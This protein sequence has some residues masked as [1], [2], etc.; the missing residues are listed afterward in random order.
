MD[1][2][3]NFERK[4]SVNLEEFHESYE[5]LFDGDDSRSEPCYLPDTYSM[6]RESIKCLASNSGESSV[7]DADRSSSAPSQDFDAENA[8]KDQAEVADEEEEAERIEGDESEILDTNNGRNPSSISSNGGYEPGSSSYNSGSCSSLSSHNIDDEDDTSTR[9]RKR[10]KHFLIISN[11]GKPIYSRYGDESKLAG[12]SA[13]LHAIISYVENSGDKIRHVRAGKHQIVFMT[14]GPIHLVCISCTEE[15]FKVLSLQLELLYAQTLLILTKSIEKYFKKNAKFDMRSLL[16]GTDEVFSSLIHLFSWNPAVFLQAYTCVPLSRHARQAISMTLQDVISSQV[17]FAILMCKNKVISIAGAQKATLHPQDLLLLSNFIVSSK[18]FRTSEAFSPICIPKYN[19]AAFLHS[20]VHYLQGETFLALLSPD[21]H[22]FYHLKECRI[23]IE[24]V[25]QKSE[26]LN[27]VRRSLESG[28]YV[29][30][31]LQSQGH[32][33]EHQLPISMRRSEGVNT[34]IGGPAGLWHFIYKNIH[35]NQYV[36]SEFS[37]I[38]YTHKAQKS[39]LRAY[40]RIH[41]SMHES[42][43]NPHKMQYKRDEHYVLF[44][45]VTLDFELYAA[46]DPLAERN[47]AIA[48]CNRVC[49]WLRDAENEIFFLDASSSVW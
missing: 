20:Y 38:F 42:T 36:A 2:G 23:K 8:L 24:T 44:C 19:S 16:G 49:Q 1:E 31:L 28:L 40:Q 45:W 14:K 22:A 32:G 13:T 27:E 33:G 18:S 37:S 4:E 25:L 46:F 17:L 26:I 47:T 9:W 15:P 3:L 6:G 7:G 10:K 29:E 11:S 48:T 34:S 5:D 41:A 39:L 30:D 21:P 35:L 12:F 43:M